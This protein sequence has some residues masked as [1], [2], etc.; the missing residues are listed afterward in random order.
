MLPR[1]EFRIKNITTTVEKDKS[2][3]SQ[4]SLHDYFFRMMKT[5]QR[6]GFT[7]Q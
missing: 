5:T 4:K 3:V 6:L 1:Q 7:L 2:L